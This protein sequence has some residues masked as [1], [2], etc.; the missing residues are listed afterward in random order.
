MEKVSIHVSSRSRVVHGRRKIVLMIFNPTSHYLIQIFWPEDFF[1]SRFYNLFD[2]HSFSFAFLLQTTAANYCIEVDV[3]N[4]LIFKLMSL[5]HFIFRKA[6][7]LSLLGDKD[8][9]EWR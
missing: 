3:E 1:F 6:E 5:Y 2:V 4:F 9:C 7:K 8:K